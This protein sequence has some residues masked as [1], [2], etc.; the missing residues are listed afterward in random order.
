MRASTVT[1]REIYH[2]SYK[3]EM[4]L[5][6]ARNHTPGARRLLEMLPDDFSR[7]EPPS[8]LTL[9]GWIKGDF[10]ERK[11]G[12]DKD[13]KDAMESQLIQE[14]VDMLYRHGRIGRHMQDKAM[15]RLDEIK[16]ED[17]P[18]H[19]AVRLLVE[20]VRIERESVGLPQALEKLLSSSDEEILDRIQ[21]IMEESPVEIL[22]LDDTTD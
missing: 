6:W 21:D 5:F 7:L 9:R 22:S 20:G 8:E 3:N 1:T 15:E 10:K 16:P 14:K 18:A 17:L 2:D 4:F 11:A 19:A 12:L 13:M